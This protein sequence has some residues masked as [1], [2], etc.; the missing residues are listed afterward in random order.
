MFLMSKKLF[1][2]I[3]L[4]TLRKERYSEKVANYLFKKVLE[5]S[6]I[7]TKLFDIKDFNLPSDEEGIPLQNQN[8]EYRDAILRADGLIIVSPEYN[9]S[10]PGSLKRSLDMLYKEYK[11]RAVGIVGVSSGI[12]GGA[13]MIES[14]AGVVKAL[15][16]VITQ[17][18]L[19]FPKVQELF[20]SDGNLKDESINKR[21]DGF[22]TDLIWLAR[23]LR[24]GRENLETEK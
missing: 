5:N 14:L 9:H 10:F 8:F 15:G 3:L 17:K 24:W 19:H 22:L 7:E 23:A 13:R 4:G 6:D 1:I 11:F 16:L 2:P 12:V 18:D 20:D 21:I